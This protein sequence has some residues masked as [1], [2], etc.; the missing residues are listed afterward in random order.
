MFSALEPNIFYFWSIV[1]YDIIDLGVLSIASFPHK[2]LLPLSIVKMSP[3]KTIQ[4]C[5]EFMLTFGT[6]EVWVF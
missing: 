5:T 6:I 4:I 3:C 2:H 1:I